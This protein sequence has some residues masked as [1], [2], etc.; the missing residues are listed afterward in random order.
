MESLIVMAA[1]LWGVPAIKTLVIII[2]GRFIPNKWIFNLFYGVGKAVTLGGSQFFKKIG[3]IWVWNKIEDIIEN[4]LMTAWNGFRAGLNSDDS[5]V[6]DTMRE[7]TD[8]V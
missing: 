3:L 2:L 4:S 8:G 7:R 1:S 6:V 5:V